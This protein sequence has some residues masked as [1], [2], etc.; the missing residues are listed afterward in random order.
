MTGKSRGRV[1]AVHKMNRYI[2]C[3]FFRSK[4]PLP[5]LIIEK[6]GAYDTSNEY[7]KDAFVDCDLPVFD[8]HLIHG[9]LEVA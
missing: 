8:E 4:L 6:R 5:F 7:S 9:G 2:T 3:I 1:I